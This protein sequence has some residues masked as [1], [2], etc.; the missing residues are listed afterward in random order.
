MSRTKL[1][2]LPALL[3]LSGLLRAQDVPNPD[4]E[5]ER[6]SFKIADGWGIKLFATDPMVEKPISMNWDAKGRLW[7]ATSETYPQVKPGQVPND[8]I[9]ILEDTQGV[10]VANRSTIWTQGLFLPTSVAPG[11][12]GAYVTNSTEILHLKDS[13]GTGKADTRRV[14][15]A[16]FGTEDTHHIIHT[17]RWGPDGRLYF[18]QSIYIHSHVETPNGI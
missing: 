14:V 9:Y 11:D 7:C 12:G 4:P 5:I 3:V 15:L 16:G 13:K 17:F 18:L 6:R 1:F 2:I 8:K 10:G